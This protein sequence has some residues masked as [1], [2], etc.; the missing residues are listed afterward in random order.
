[1]RYVRRSTKAAH[2]TATVAVVIVVIYIFIGFHC[3]NNIIVI[4]SP[5]LSIVAYVSFTF[6]SP[7]SSS[8]ALWSSYISILHTFSSISKAQEMPPVFL[9][10]RPQL[11]LTRLSPVRAI[12]RCRYLTITRC[13]FR[14]IAY[15]SLPVINFKLE[16]VLRISLRCT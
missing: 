5:E 8:S 11:F 10:S 2:L 6:D 4:C 15:I 9:R 7:M 14:P 13:V 1:M 12:A 3:S 16:M